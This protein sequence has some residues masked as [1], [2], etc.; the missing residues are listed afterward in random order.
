M[1]NSNEPQ[2]AM[3]NPVLDRPLTMKEGQGDAGS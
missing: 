2:A 1:D 3:S